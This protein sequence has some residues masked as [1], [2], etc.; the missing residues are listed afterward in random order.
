MRAVWGGQLPERIGGHLLSALRL[1]VLLQFCR[2]GR[3][4]AVRRRLVRVGTSAHRVCCLPERGIFWGAGDD[5]PSLCIRELLG[6]PGLCVHSLLG[7]ELP[8]SPVF[9]HPP[10]PINRPGPGPG[11]PLGLLSPP[12]RFGGG[13]RRHTRTIRGPVCRLWRRHL[14]GCAGER[15]HGLLGRRLLGCECDGL[16]SMFSRQLLGCAGECLHHLLSWQLL[17]CQRVYK[18][19]GLLCRRVLVSAGRLRVPALL[20]RQFLGC[21]GDG[22]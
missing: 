13:Y 17:G 8:A 19:P 18:L 1:R 15:L 5:L 4:P 2:V 16:Q 7:R 11:S 14:L 12:A 3:V 9:R 21:A 20:R 10:S 6:R 22:L